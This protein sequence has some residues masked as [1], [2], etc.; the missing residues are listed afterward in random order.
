MIVGADNY[1]AGLT[2]LFG[3][4]VDATT[5]PNTTKHADSAS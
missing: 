3:L 5:A 1:L 2:E 4:S